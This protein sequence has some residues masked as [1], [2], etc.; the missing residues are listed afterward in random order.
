MFSDAK[1]GEEVMKRYFD[2][3]VKELS[4]SKDRQTRSKV[5]SIKNYNLFAKRKNVALAFTFAAVNKRKDFQ[6]Y[7]SNDIKRRRKKFK[8]KTFFTFLNMICERYVMEHEDENKVLREL[9]RV[10]N[11]C[12]TSV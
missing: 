7:L 12:I 6:K 4:L 8:S 3:A 2:L 10:T 1:E 11:E 9:R 5:E